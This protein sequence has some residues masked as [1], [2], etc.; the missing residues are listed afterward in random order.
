MLYTK[1]NDQYVLSGAIFNGEIY[2]AAENHWGEY[3]ELTTNQEVIDTYKFQCLANK[4][5]PFSETLPFLSKEDLKTLVI[6]EIPLIPK[7]QFLKLTRVF[8]HFADRHLEAGAMLLHSPEH[9]YKFVI[10]KHTVVN[11][12]FCSTG[13][14]DWPFVDLEGNQT[15]IKESL[16]HGY[17]IVGRF[18]S[19]HSMAPIPSG[20]DDQ[21]EIG[22]GLLLC[23]IT[24]NVK[25][26]PFTKE[27]TWENKLSLASPHGRLFVKEQDYI[28]PYD[29][30]EIEEVYP[31][32]VPKI[33]IDYISAGLT[34]L[35]TFP[36][37]P[38][39]PS[40]T[41]PTYSWLPKPKANK[42]KNTSFSLSMLLDDLSPATLVRLKEE[43]EKKLCEYNYPL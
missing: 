4:I 6:K 22:K 3:F 12:A 26:N 27:V 24:G 10:G 32:G 8:L 1:E 9:G 33:I 42:R 37:L 20:I 17:S 41:E 38:S 2:R 25:K 13:G 5:T 30:H 34:P 35:P 21:D 40:S 15:T 29:I 19:H 14:K 18:H 39:L 28:E 7:D 11:G 36:S 16:E 31:E 23:C 43:I